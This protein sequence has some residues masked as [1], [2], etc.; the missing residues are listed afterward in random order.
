MFKAQ[1][2][3][4]RAKPYQPL[5]FL[6]RLKP[7]RTPPPDGH[8]RFHQAIRGHQS[9]FP[10]EIQPR[11]FVGVKQGEIAKTSAVKAACS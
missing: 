4:G 10:F 8:F 7:S 9:E 3:P 2:S 5:F 6:G 11:T 1:Q